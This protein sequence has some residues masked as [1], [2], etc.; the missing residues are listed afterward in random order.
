MGKL[1]ITSTVG[2]ME[3]SALLGTARIL[4]YSDGESKDESILLA[5]G[6]LL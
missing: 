2:V 5:F 1:G 4:E 6:H 3:K